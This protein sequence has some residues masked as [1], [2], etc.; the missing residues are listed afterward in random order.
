[1]NY[2]SNYICNSSF[3]SVNIFKVS[4]ILLEDFEIFPM[5][6]LIFLVK[7]LF[8]YNPIKNSL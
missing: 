3:G 2:S 6:S 8:S 1:M 4:L 7:I 5:Y